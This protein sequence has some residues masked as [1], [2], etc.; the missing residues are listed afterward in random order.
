MGKAKIIPIGKAK[1]TTQDKIKLAAELAVFKRAIR[2]RVTRFTQHTSTCNHLVK[3]LT[4]MIKE[5]EIAVE[6]GTPLHKIPALSRV[7]HTLNDIDEAMKKY[8]D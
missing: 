1:L 2:P 3:D 5:V 8:H 4:K 6:D 7:I